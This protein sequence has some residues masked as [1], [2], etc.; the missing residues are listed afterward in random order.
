VAVI[1]GSALTTLEEKEGEYGEPAIEKLLNAIDNNLPTP[2]REVDK[3]FLMAVEAIYN[4]SGRGSVCTGMPYLLKSPID[5]DF[6][7]SFCVNIGVV[8]QG[9][10]K[11]GDNVEVV[12]MN[13]ENKIFSASVTGIETFHKQ[14]D[15]G[16]AGDSVGL[17]LRGPNRNDLK[18]GQIVCKPGSI[19]P[20]KRFEAQVRHHNYG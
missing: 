5:I 20:H 11:V 6:F 12:G 3:P 15:D 17:L 10:V 19:K 8:E 16:R 4:V 13:A 9:T 2:K 18:R 7:S 1:H 14:L